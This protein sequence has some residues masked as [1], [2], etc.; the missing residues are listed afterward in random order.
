MTNCLPRRRNRRVVIRYDERDDENLRKEK[1]SG[2]ID[3][4]AEEY[5]FQ[6]IDDAALAPAA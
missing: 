2:R 3:G 1:S 4:L 5:F 6:Y